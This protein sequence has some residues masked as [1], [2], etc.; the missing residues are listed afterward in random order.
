M[1]LMSIMGQQSLHKETDAVELKE[2]DGG[3]IEI[4]HLNIYPMSEIDALADDIRRYGLQ[5][6]LEV[7]LDEASGNY[8]LLGGER[9]Y[10]AIL[11]L[12]NKGEWTGPI[13][14]L[15]Y[16]QPATTANER[17]SLIR[18][19]AQRDMSKAEIMQIVAELEDLYNELKPGGRKVEWIA[20][21][22][23]KSPRTVQSLLDKI[24]GKDSNEKEAAAE[25]GTESEGKGVKIDL[26]KEKKKLNKIFVKLKEAIETGQIEELITYVNKTG[27]EKP[28]TALD[29]L[30]TA[31]DL[32]W[33]LQPNQE[34]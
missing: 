28:T 4:N 5:K 30:E 11:E 12:Q 29:V 23:G 1:S 18:S 6:P 7:Y 19:N 14:C 8:I 21:Y 9:R 27:E 2:I 31:H 20:P 3:D 34:H 16:A 10:R 22:I 32:L 26:A 24:H 15:V 17:L 25:S 13:K 33:L